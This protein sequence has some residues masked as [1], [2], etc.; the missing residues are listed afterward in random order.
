MCKFDQSFDS[1]HIIFGP[2]V[3]HEPA[4]VFNALKNLQFS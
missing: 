4:I 1:F 3:L 2:Q